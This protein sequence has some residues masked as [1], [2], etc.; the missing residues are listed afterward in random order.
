MAGM[1]F[2][3]EIQ[4]FVKMPISPISEVQLKIDFRHLAT[5]VELICFRYT[6]PILIKTFLDRFWVTFLFLR[7]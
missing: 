1:H 7:L 6:T 3:G 5:I 2:K 4:N